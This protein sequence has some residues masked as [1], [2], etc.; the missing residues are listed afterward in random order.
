MGRP[1]EALPL[2]HRALTIT[3]TILGPGHPDTATRRDDLAALRRV[4][5][6]EGDDG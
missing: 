3:E 6:G 5:A 4:L 1:A 2:A